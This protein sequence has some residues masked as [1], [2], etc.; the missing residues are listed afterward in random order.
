VSGTADLDGDGRRDLAV[1]GPSRGV[2]G[3]HLA[4]QVLLLSSQSGNLLGTLDG[5]A[6][7]DAFGRSTDGNWDLNNDGIE[8]LIVGAYLQD[9]GGSAAGR[10]YVYLLGDADGD[11][12]P[13]ACDNCAT[14]ANP[15]QSDPDSDG[16]GSRCDVCPDVPDTVDTDG[17]GA[18]DACDCQP[19]DSDS[20]P[21]GDVSILSAERL[22]DQSVRLGWQ[23]AA[24]GD[25][26]SVT[27][28][29]LA[30]LDYGS[31]GDCVAEDVAGVEFEDSGMPA[32]GQGFGYLVQGESLACGLGLLGFDSGEGV[33][34]N[35]DAGACTDP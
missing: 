3:R 23:A 1:A 10:V 34:A 20:L 30:S 17:D 31:Y 12:L 6:D 35:L 27:R 33:R 32:P 18:A 14:K 2:P 28:G 7:G 22:L 24:G 15:L 4:G 26:Y 5:E 11:G 19:G 29:D 13:A 21:P 16:I 8:D 9:T 25:T